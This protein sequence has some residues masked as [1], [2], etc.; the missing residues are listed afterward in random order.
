MASVSRSAAPH[1][2]SGGRDST[3][4][5]PFLAS[6]HVVHLGRSRQRSWDGSERE[7][8]VQTVVRLVQAVRS[9]R[10]KGPMCTSWTQA[11]IQ[12]PSSGSGA[13]SS[14]PRESRMQPIDHLDDHG[15]F[16]AALVTVE[17]DLRSSH[18]ADARRRRAIG[19]RCGP[20]NDF[21][22]GGGA[23]WPASRQSVM[24]HRRS[25]ARRADG[26]PWSSKGSRRRFVYRPWPPR[27]RG[28]RGPAT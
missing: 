1:R 25:S 27:V 26:R 17:E 3:G 28:A 16:E 6:V 19:S 13:P 5:P 15:R 21:R 18:G 4:T 10:D 8:A 11:K 24:I 2:P 23:I 22:P 12:V 9:T 7:P 20:T 14:P